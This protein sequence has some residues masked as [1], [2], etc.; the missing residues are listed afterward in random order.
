ADPASVPA[1]WRAYFEADDST[2][3]AGASLLGAEGCAG[4][5]AAVSGV[6]ATKLAKAAPAVG[7]ESSA[8]K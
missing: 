3:T 4:A 2:P 6:A 5:G 7:V 1:A 8:S